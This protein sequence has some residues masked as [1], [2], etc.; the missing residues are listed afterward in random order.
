[1][2]WAPRADHPVLIIE[3]QDDGSRKNAKV[4]GQRMIQP[5]KES[6]QDVLDYLSNEL[7]YIVE[8]LRDDDGVETWDYLAYAL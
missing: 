3:I 5:N 2:P 4:G 7:G 1:M 6:R 8:A